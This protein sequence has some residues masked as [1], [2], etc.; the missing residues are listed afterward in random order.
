MNN[1]DNYNE[2]KLNDNINNKEKINSNNKI[3][4]ENIN[5]NRNVPSNNIKE[6]NLK[7]II[8]NA[9]SLFNYVKKIFLVDILRTE[10]PDIAIL[11]ETFLL[12]EDTLYAKG[13]RT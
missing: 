11:S 8:W 1:I 6:V 10:A 9:R 7:V 13:Y 3:I 12:E 5:P 4:K 2:I